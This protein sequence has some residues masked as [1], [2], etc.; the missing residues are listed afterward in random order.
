MTGGERLDLI[1]TLRTTG[2]VREFTDDPVDDA[3]VHRILDTARFAPSGGNRQGWRVILVKDRAR[4]ELLRDLQMPIEAEY[5]DA[6]IAGR[7]AFAPGYERPTGPVGEHTFGFADHLDNH[8]VV[9]LVLA[10]LATLSVTDQFL[11]R[12]SIV[13]GASVY[14]FAHDILLAARAEGLGGVMTT[15][16]SAAEVPVA[17]AFA[18]PPTHAL[19][20][21]IALGVPT[22]RVTRLRRNPVESFTTI[23]SFDGPPL[24]PV[25]APSATAE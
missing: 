24:G 23:D 5:V 15:L 6:L 18:I 4:R 8:P 13:G 20:A 2:A 1:E 16:S 3:T 22:R 10:E 9:L 25:R 14:P 19:A 11:D 17:E 21:L 7:T 12:P